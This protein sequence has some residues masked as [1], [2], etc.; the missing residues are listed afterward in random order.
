MISAFVSGQSE[1][2]AVKQKSQYILYDIDQPIK[3]VEVNSATL[4]LVFA[5]CNDLQTIL[6]SSVDEASEHAINLADADIALRYFLILL[7]SGHQKKRCVPEIA[8]SLND[9]LKNSFVYDVVRNNLFCHEFPINVERQAVR[10]ISTNHSRFD[11]LF[12]ETISHQIEIKKVRQGFDEIPSD[13]FDN[14]KHRSQFKEEAIRNGCFFKLATEPANKAIF[15]IY[16]ALSKVYN[17]R[18]IIQEW[19]KNFEIDHSSKLLKLKSDDSDDNFESGKKHARARTGISGRQA[20][21]NAKLQQI[22]VLDKI[23]VG[24]ISRA[25]KFAEELVASQTQTGDPEHVSKS[26]CQLSQFAKE[27]QI[28][29][30]E[31]EWAQEA[32]RIDPSDARAHSQVGDALIRL[33]RFTE[34]NAALEK[35]SA[36]GEVQYALIGKARIQRATGH[37]EEAENI[38]LEMINKFPSDPERVFALAGL[39]EIARDQGNLERALEKYQE[40]VKIEPHDPVY[41]NGL[42]ATFAQMG[43]FSTALEHYNTSLSY[44]ENDVVTLNGIATIYK[45]MG[46][47]DLA[48]EKFSN[49]AIKFPH[50][51]FSRSALGDIYK[52]QGKFEEAYQQLKKTSDELPFS[53]QPLMALASTYSE[54]G[55]HDKAREV[56]SVGSQKFPYEAFFAT[57]LGHSLRKSGQ[58]QSALKIFD[59]ARQKFPNDNNARLGRADMLRRLG[60]VEAA[61]KSYQNIFEEEPS[62]VPTQNG[63][64]SLLIYQGKFTEAK[65]YLI[66]GNPQ[67]QDEW[68]SQIIKGMIFVK[69]QEFEIAESHFEKLLRSVPFAR[70]RRIM[71]A[72]L[73]SIYI[74]RKNFHAALRNSEGVEG[75]VTELIRLHALA[76]AKMNS[77]YEVLEGFRS[78]FPEYFSEVREEIAAQFGLNDN[79]PS[80][81]HNWLV[82]E[83]QNILLLEAA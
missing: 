82:R 41:R 70:E 42:A 75:E 44:S 31:L 24:D 76:G 45:T 49:I 6:V 71:K 8:H 46:N 77:A 47:L 5:D 14:A 19:T 13:K 16:T 67:T 2:F 39:A 38:F 29:E 74:E 11:R 48:V 58:Y 40:A 17:S 55:K 22:A 20:Y 1:K 3:G 7:N 51:P 50:D 18:N 32:A 28:Y 66:E 26:L 33:H 68:R 35:A 54:W 73:A 34:A 72:I 36:F 59:D 30:L 57:G 83:E 69:Q 52:L 78:N 4:R 21:E 23:R 43:N 63:L 25:R 79:S 61:L 27:H 10:E 56:F 60:Q 37:L 65:R 15:Y 12:D 64:A 62:H 53:P 80:H 9:L 81:D